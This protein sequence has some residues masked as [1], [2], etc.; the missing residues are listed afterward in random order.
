MV[1]YR[2]RSLFSAYPGYFWGM[3]QPSFWFFLHMILGHQRGVLQDLIRLVNVSLG[4]NDLFY[5]YS[6]SYQKDILYI[7][8]RQLFTYLLLP[9]FVERWATLVCVREY[10]EFHPEH[11]CRLISARRTR[12]TDNSWPHWEG[13]SPERGPHLHLGVVDME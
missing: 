1:T 10:R 4:N 13:S 6:T 2:N 3:M 11:R 7:V 8:V 5:K 12:G 9:G